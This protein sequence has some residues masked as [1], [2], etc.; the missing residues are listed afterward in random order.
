M[1]ESQNLK[2]EDQTEKQWKTLWQYEI[3]AKNSF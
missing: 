1:V 3:L 2:K